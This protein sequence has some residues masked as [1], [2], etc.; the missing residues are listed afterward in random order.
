MVAVA[1]FYYCTSASC[2]ENDKAHVC[3]GCVNYLQ[4]EICLHGDPHES[5]IELAGM[6][7]L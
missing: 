2:T 5:T 4:N 1:T 6:Y 7:G 3:R